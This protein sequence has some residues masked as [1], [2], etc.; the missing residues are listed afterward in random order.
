MN[1]KLAK[2]TI[3]PYLHSLPSSPPLRPWEELEVFAI[4]KG[5]LS[6]SFYL[7]AM[8]CGWTHWLC[9]LPLNTKQMMK[10]VTFFFVTSQRRGLKHDP[11]LWQ[12]H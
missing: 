3:L 2:S 11:C 10:E 1:L 5:C 12:K 8:I 9:G 6:Q 4:L 7:Q